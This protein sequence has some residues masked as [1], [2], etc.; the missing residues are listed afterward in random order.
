MPFTVPDEFIAERKPALGNPEPALRVPTKVALCLKWLKLK[1][2]VSKQKSA[3]RIAEVYGN[4]DDAKSAAAAALSAGTLDT[5][6]IASFARS[7]YG[8]HIQATGGAVEGGFGSIS[9]HLQHKHDAILSIMTATNG[10]RY[11]VAAYRSGGKK[12]LKPHIYIF[13]PGIGELIPIK[14]KDLERGFGSAI[15]LKDGHRIAST[16]TVGV[17]AY[18]SDEEVLQETV[19]TNYEGVNFSDYS[20]LNFGFSAGASAAVENSVDY[21]MIDLSA[22]DG[23]YSLVTRP[24]VA[25]KPPHLKP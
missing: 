4:L 6:R 16:I 23:V 15:G 21:E 11:P 17:R 3:S 7:K 22:T 19:A 8:L 25:P 2:T 1:T 24:P 12:G 20:R 18:K 5:V 10:F 14:P 13:L 9:E